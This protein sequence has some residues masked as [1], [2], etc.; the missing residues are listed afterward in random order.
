MIDLKKYNVNSDDYIFLE[1]LIFNI[2]DSQMSVNLIFDNKYSFQIDPCGNEFEVWHL[3]K[4][5]NTFKDLDDLLYNF[6]IDEKP[7]IE[8]LSQ[9]VYE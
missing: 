6:I 4:K 8:Q 5:I 1:D 3:G 7:F 2:V 9:I